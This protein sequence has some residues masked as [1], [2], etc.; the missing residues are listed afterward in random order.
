MWRSKWFKPLL[1]LAIGISIFFFFMVNPPLSEKGSKPVTQVLQVTTAPLRPSAQPITIYA[2]GQVIPELETIVKAQ[3]SGEIIKISPEFV[4]GGYVRKHETL[5]FV[6]PSDYRLAVAKQH[7]KLNQAKADFA[8]EMGRQEI[9]KDELDLIAKSTGQ[10]FKNTQLALRQP[11]LAQAQAN[12]DI[13]EADLAQAQLDLTRTNVLAP[14]NA[15]VISRQAN[16]GDKIA[17]QDRLARIVSTDAYWITLSLPVADLKW[18][19]ISHEQNHGSK[20]IIELDANRGKRQG[21]LFKLTGQMNETSRL[22]ELLVKV[23]DPLLLQSTQTQ[24]QLILNDFVGVK[25]I[26]KTL[27][28]VMRIPLTAVRDQ[29]TLWIARDNQLTILKVTPL[30]QGDNYILVANNFLSDDRL[31]LSDIAIPV[32]GMKI[33]LAD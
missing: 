26:G 3:V 27:E 7:A 23:D 25:L 2:M 11:Q 28:N 31:I 18:L 30:Y 5:L 19:N 21:Y 22:V 29:D 4:P 14:Y 1:I 20:A 17:G 8:L 32:A 10:A 12:I 9:A 13:A 16:L 6:D 24:P 33:R 15:L